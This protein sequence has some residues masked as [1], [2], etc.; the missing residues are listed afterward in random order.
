MTSH[1]YE[2][3][4]TTSP[5]QRYQDAEHRARDTYLSITHRAHLEYLTGPRPDR[6]A[7]NHVEITAWMT[8]Y[9]AGRSAWLTYLGEISRPPAPE[10]S[11]DLSTL[12][13][14][15]SH[16]TA[17]Y[18]P[19]CLECGTPWDKPSPG[20][21]HVTWDVHPR[22]ATFT[23]HQQEQANP[24]PQT[25]ATRQYCPCC[26]APDADHTAYDHVDECPHP[27]YTPTRK[28]D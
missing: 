22:Q 2:T 11:H 24:A 1:N 5:W 9:A 8:Y 12:A 27:A 25:P 13:G 20:C 14:T 17:Q 7:Y 21:P 16:L 10:P 18:G 3:H 19:N 26:D 4:A 15:R 6:D 23:S 28:A